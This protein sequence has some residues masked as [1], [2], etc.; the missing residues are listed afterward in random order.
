MTSQVYI[1]C[2]Y[3]GAAVTTNLQGIPGTEDIRVNN[4]CEEL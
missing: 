3:C 2:A 4:L 1:S